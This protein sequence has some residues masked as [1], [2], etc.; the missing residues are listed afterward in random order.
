MLFWVEYSWLAIFCLLALSIYSAILFNLQSFCWKFAD[1]L[2]GIPL[3]IM[4]FF[5]CFFKNF[6]L[7]FN[8]YHVNYNVSPCMSCWI[9]LF[10]NVLGFL[11]LYAYL[12]PQLGK[13]LAI[14]SSNKLSAHLLRLWLLYLSTGALTCSISPVIYLYTFWFCFSFFFYSSWVISTVLSLSL[15]MF[16]FSFFSIVDVLATLGLSCF[17]K[18]LQS[19]LHCAESLV[20]ACRLLTVA[21]GI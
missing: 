15:L 11:D 19:S 21:R 3:C 1:G 18:D 5:S 9:D 2:V 14:I 4:L 12:F 16:H 6:L 8:F 20:E 7:F 10:W 13:F 17:I